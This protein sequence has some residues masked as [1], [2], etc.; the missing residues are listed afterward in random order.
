MFQVSGAGLDLVDAEPSNGMR[1]VSITVHEGVVYVLNS[2]E[3]TDGLK[4]VPVPLQGAVVD[5]YN[6][7]RM[8]MS[9]A[10]VGLRV[11]GVTMISRSATLSYQ[12]PDRDVRSIARE[13]GA[14]LIVD[15]AV[16]ASH[17]TVRVTL[18]EIEIPNQAY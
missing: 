4:I 16:Q 13:L 14:D 9:L 10:L 1:P 12:K 7:H 5:T 8:A 11:P 3:T 15:G 2:D 18:N 6:D 17:D